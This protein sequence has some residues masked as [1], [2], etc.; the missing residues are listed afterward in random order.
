MKRNPLAK[1]LTRQAILRFYLVLGSAFFAVWPSFTYAR[2]IV[3]GSGE[4]VILA[5]RPLRIV[6]LVPSLGELAADFLKSDPG[7]IIG[8]SEYTDY[9]PSLQKVTSI[10]SY[11]HLNLE[12]ILSLKP[13]LVLATLDGNRKDEISHLRE[14]H[15]PVV[16]VKTGSF[17][18]I[19]SSIQLVA[20]VLGKVK[21]GEEIVE[22]LNKGL[23][24]FR[25]RAKTR[26]SKKVMLQVG[27]DPLSVVGKKSFLHDAIELVGASNIYADADAH[28]PK[29]SLEDILKRDPDFIIV[30]AMGADIVP[31]LKM[32]SKW[33][34]FPRLSAVK[35]KRVIL[36]KSDALLRPT[37]RIL[38]GLAQLE[39]TIYGKN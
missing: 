11:I 5:D 3:D 22:R 18:E 33:Q 6:T 34:Q 31:Y 13:D 4:K 19:D 2:E 36:L 16:V 7:R 15:V 20:T 30:A 26:A 12:K 8:V 27:D 14:L 24:Q 29:P 1:V 39:Q 25:E 21:E 23:M 10:G 17:K 38:G 9:P 37:V 28:Y 32:V 35:N